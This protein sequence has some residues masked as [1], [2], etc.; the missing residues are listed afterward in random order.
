MFEDI[1]A[2]LFGPSAESVSQYERAR[3]AQEQWAKRVAAENFALG[4]NFHAQ[5]ACRKSSESPAFPGVSTDDTPRS[6]LKAASS[7]S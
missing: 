4:A 2:L 6:E 3:A 1:L 7:K 5:D